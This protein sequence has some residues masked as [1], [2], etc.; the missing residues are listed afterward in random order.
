MG[1]F[2]SVGEE[3]RTI[4]ACNNGLPDLLSRWSHIIPSASILGRCYLL[5]KTSLLY[6]YKHFS[7][8]CGYLSAVKVDPGF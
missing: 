6:K 5:W 1:N 4:K 8:D 7:K 3:H 2:V